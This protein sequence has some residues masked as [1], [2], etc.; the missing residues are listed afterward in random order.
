M[1]I[2]QNSNDVFEVNPFE[3][4]EDDES[5]PNVGRWGKFLLHILKVFFVLYSGVH[6][7]QASLIATGDVWYAQVTQIL[8]VLTLEASILAIYMAYLGGKIT[9]TVQTIIAGLFWVIGVGMAGAGIV[10]D[11]RLHAG[12]ELGSALNWYLSTGLYIAPLIMVVGIVMIAFA[13]PV[14]SQHIANARDRATIAR[15]KVLAQVMAEKATHEARKIA[16]A[17]RLNAQKQIA[18]EATRYYKSGEIQQL[19]REKA[20]AHMDTLLAQEFG[21]NVTLPAPVQPE[22]LPAP[23]E[24]PINITPPNRRFR[25]TRHGR[26]RSKRSPISIPIDAIPPNL[27][28]LIENLR[29]LPQEEFN[30]RVVELFKKLGFQVTVGEEETSGDNS[31]SPLS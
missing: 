12:Q 16:H 5:Y 10:A 9:G 8:G 21:I 18:Q 2:D 22:A 29:D 20:R 17:V 15:Q 27:Q 1:T 11:S 19:V 3:T 6:N 23:A 28:P 30:Q 14:I 26:R 4:N 25:P 13:D 31:H 7:V 24:E